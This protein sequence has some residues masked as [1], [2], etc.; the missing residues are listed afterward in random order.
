MLLKADSVLPLP[1]F[2]SERDVVTPLFPAPLESL[3]REPGKLGCRSLLF[4]ILLRLSQISTSCGVGR[5]GRYQSSRELFQN[6]CDQG[7]DPD[8][9]LRMGRG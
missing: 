6:M 7:A 1:Y 4:Q 5:N 8:L 2:I 3:S 9:L